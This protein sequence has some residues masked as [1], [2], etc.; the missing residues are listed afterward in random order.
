MNY[1]SVGVSSIISNRVRIFVIILP[2]S[3]YTAFV[4]RLFLSLA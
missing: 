1:R 4:V 3:R 2:L